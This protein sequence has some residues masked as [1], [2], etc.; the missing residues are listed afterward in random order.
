[1]KWVL[2]SV[3]LVLLL[4]LAAC[5]SPPSQESLARTPRP[6]CPTPT[7]QAELLD[8]AL[9]SEHSQGT[10]DGTVR[11]VQHQQLV[12]ECGYGDA[13]RALHKHN[14][15]DSLSDMGSIAKTF[16]AA[17]VLQ[18]HIEGR[19][20]L[21]AR[22]SEFY[23]EAPVD[24]RDISIEQLLA[25]QSGLDNFHNQSDFDPMNRDEAEKLILSMPL[26]SAPGG[27]ITYSNAAYTLLAAIVERVS[28]IAFRDYVHQQLLAPLKLNSTGFY[29]DKNLDVERLAKGYGGQ[30]SGQSTFAKPLTWAL[31]GAGGMV[32]SVADLQRW[33]DALQGGGQLP[34]ELT[35][36]LFQPVNKKWT[37]G[38]WAISGSNG[39]SIWQMGGSNDYGYTAL[40]QYV[41]ER[42]LLV[43]LMFNAY[44]K[45]YANATHHR[46]SRNVLLPLLI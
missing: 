40:V 37:L 12:F 8:Q 19:L 2:G 20:P 1:M 45:K 28:G 18:L 26:L 14:D 44:S 15:V 35:S 17:A 33:F 22:L 43:V 46:I 24:K 32:S 5:S 41:P 38:N 16:T 36:L 21:T 31:I 10:F 25:H 3:S 11:I 39:M 27:D 6:F 13:D 29:G 9:T 23:P 4:T 34:A 42:D 7:E 30:D